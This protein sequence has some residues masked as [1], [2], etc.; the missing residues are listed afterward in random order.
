MR[1]S[2][3]LTVAGT[4]LALCGLIIFL[5]VTGRDP[6][7][8]LSTLPLV[9][10]ALGN[11]YKVNKVDHQTNGTN[12]ALRTENAQLRSI[13]SPSQASLVPVYTVSS[14]APSV[15]TEPAQGQDL[16]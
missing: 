14:T 12:Q 2:Y 9:I 8:F 5:I 15:P 3:L 11:L 4:F 10:A 16:G 6:A 13:L 1:L 7:L